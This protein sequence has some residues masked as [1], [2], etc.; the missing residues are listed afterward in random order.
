MPGSQRR[1]KLVFT[2]IVLGF[3]VALGGCGLTASRAVEQVQEAITVTPMPTFAPAALEPAGAGY[4]RDKLAALG[5]AEDAPGDAEGVRRNGP[6]PVTLSRFDRKIIKNAELT[7]QVKDTDTAIDQLTGLVTD[8]DGYIV[9]SR[10]WSEGQYR[11][12]TVTLSIPVDTFEQVLRRL[13][14]I[15]VEVLSERA[16]GQDV[17]DQY[18]D[19]E[20]RLRNLEATQ[21]RVR[22][23][24]DQ[25]VTV[26]EAL[27]VNHQLSQIEG[28][29]ED[30]KGKMNYLKERASYSSITVQL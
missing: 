9:S 6:V 24:L 1:N 7:L 14:G 4:A 12:A 19:L 18:V 2:V 3:V 30:I 22:A 16:D 11:M 5:G 29:I 15:A 21:T 26:E 13:R 17:T 10:A 8:Y 25:A 20:S 28:Q 23:F 27:E